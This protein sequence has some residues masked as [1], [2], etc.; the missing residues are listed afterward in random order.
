MRERGNHI[1][2]DGWMRYVVLRS[3]C[4]VPPASTSRVVRLSMRHYWQAATM[5]KRRLVTST[6]TTA[7]ANEAYTVVIPY[8]SI[9]SKYYNSVCLFKNSYL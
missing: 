8:F 1:S 7:T 2:R 3:N 6:T 4:R 5:E 9:T